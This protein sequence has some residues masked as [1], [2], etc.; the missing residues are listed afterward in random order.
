MKI[1]LKD[2]KNKSDLK[3]FIEK[4]V[5][6][7]FSKTSPLK[8]L[9]KEILED[10]EKVKS[11]VNN[12]LNFEKEVIFKLIDIM[13]ILLSIGATLLIFSFSVND[14]PYININILRL[15]SGGLIIFS[16]ILIVILLMNMY[17]S[18][19][20]IID[21]L[22]KREFEAIGTDIKSFEEKSEN[23]YKELTKELDGK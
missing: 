11:A 20:R 4:S 7:S 14:V 16:L 12:K 6:S 22:L 3:L 13:G 19:N 15:T 17:Y 10:Y 1:E 2:I 21:V 23:V 9:N 8:E 18:H 5:K